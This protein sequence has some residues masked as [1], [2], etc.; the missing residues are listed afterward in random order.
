MTGQS[1]VLSGVPNFRD[2]A[3]TVPALKPGLLLRSDL[4]Y[5]P[6]E[7]EA[8][9]IAAYGIQLVV[10]LR[11][12][13]E[14]DRLPNRWFSAQG[15]EIAA[16]DM[17]ASGDPQAMAAAWQSGE[18]AEGAHALMVEVYRGFPEGALPVLAMLGA[19]IVA[20]ELPVL[21]HCAA[22][23]DRTGFLVAAILMAIGI[24]A[25]EVEAD[26]LAS[27][28]RVHPRT[29]DHTRHAMRHVGELD[30]AALARISGVHRD[31]LHAA[32]AVVDSAYGGIDAY[33]AR[34]G[35]D[36]AMRAAMG[37]RLLR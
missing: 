33:L 36:A 24:G 3:Q 20:G 29:L 14:R 10:D 19:R 9:L 4:V 7:A 34:A 30:E 31:F 21:M 18:G 37:R 2:V 35:L 1:H 26:Y 13:G 15:T 17:A 8:R 32:L 5:E 22:G 28:G 16:H 6:D 23:K 25:G 27:A 11:G 12:S